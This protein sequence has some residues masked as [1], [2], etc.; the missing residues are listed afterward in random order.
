MTLSE[1][2]DQTLPSFIFLNRIETVS[3]INVKGLSSNAAEILHFLPTVSRLTVH[4][5]M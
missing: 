3:T 4:I 2:L 5:A 1:N